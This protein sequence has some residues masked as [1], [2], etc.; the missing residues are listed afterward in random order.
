MLTAHRTLVASTPARSV[1]IG[2]YRDKAPLRLSFAGGGTDVPPFPEREGGLVLSATIDRHSYGT[3]R[4]RLDRQIAIQSVDYG[5]E[6][7][8]GVDEAMQFDGRLDLV[9]AAI[10]RFGNGM[11]GGFDL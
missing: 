2:S 10:R 8:W 4:P 5:M 7:N 3:L 11:R 6:V 1:R 9:K